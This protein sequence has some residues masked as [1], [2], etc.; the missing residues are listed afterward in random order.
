MKRPQAS[1]VLP[2]A[3]L[4]LQPQQGMLEE[5]P[6]ARTTLEQGSSGPTSLAVLV[7][8][9]LEIT[10]CLNGR[11]RPDEIHRDGYE[12]MSAGTRIN[13]EDGTTYL[14]TLMFLSTPWNQGLERPVDGSVQASF[15]HLSWLPL[16]QGELWYIDFSEIA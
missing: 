12:G 11:C 8:R 2:V 13:G 9:F 5:H 16:Q 15:C 4:E 3:L 1:A 7:A 10:E 14:Q 6:K